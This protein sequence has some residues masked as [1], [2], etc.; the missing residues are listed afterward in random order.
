MKF[1]VLSLFL[2]LLFELTLLY[3]RR[4]QGL[5]FIYAIL[6]ASFSQTVF[7]VP[8]IRIMAIGILI[9]YYSVNTSPVEILPLIRRIIKYLTLRGLNVSTIAPKIIQVSKSIRVMFYFRSSREFAVS[10]FLRTIFKKCLI[11]E[12]VCAEQS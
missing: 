10:L 8:G 9:M 7:T 6:T 11:A 12:L 2:V 1:R 5:I 3:K 4:V